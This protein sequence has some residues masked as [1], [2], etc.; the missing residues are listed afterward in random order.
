VRLLVHA[1]RE[2]RLRREA[3]IDILVGVELR[4]RPPSDLLYLFG[5][6]RD[7]PRRRPR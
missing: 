2:R 5:N 7:A 4:S 1:A 3:A 6:P